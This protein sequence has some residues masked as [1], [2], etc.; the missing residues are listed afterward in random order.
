MLDAVPASSRV[1]LGR[2]SLRRL[3]SAVLAARAGA[4]HVYAIEAS[5]LAAKSIAN[6]K[7][8]GLENVITYVLLFRTVN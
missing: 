8:N 6:V 3:I 5:G 1:R 7:K 4:K 2:E